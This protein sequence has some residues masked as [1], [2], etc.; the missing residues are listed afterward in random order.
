MDILFLGSFLPSTYESKFEN[1]SAAGNQFQ[2]NL[3]R[4]AKRGHNVSVLSYISV[5]GFKL[6]EY[7]ENELSSKNFHIYSPKAK[8]WLDFLYYRIHMWKLAKKN[9]CVIVYNMVYAW[10]GIGLISSLFGMRSILILADYTPPCEEKSIVR[11]IYSYFVKMN[12]NLFDKIILLSEGSRMYIKE[13]K[14][15][16]LFHGCIDWELFKDITPIQNHET[17]NVVYTG[18]IGYVTGVDLLLDAFVKI[19]GDN[20]RLYICGQGF[21]LNDLIK[22]YLDKDKRIIYKGYLSKPEYIMMLKDANVLVN[23]RNM[24]LL[25][26][27]SNFPSKIL[28]YIATGRPI[29]STKFIGWNSFNNNIFFCESDSKDISLAIEQSL[30]LN[31]HDT[32]LIYDKNRK[33]IQ[34]FKWE[35]WIDSILE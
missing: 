7:E 12:F 24:K 21:E 4:A 27:I 5:P 28:E 17:F 30:R 31:N 23:P 8:G 6:N 35:K 22:E 11:K 33:Y 16:M 1:L 29:I 9:D 10:F 19:K 25:Q 14:K 15:T 32:S 18:F 20:L 2:Y 13:K 26:N 3:Y 34:N